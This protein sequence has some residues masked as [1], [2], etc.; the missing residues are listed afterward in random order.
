VLCFDLWSGWQGWRPLQ[1][2]DPPVEKGSFLQVDDGV[3]WSDG[4]PGRPV[5]VEHASFRARTNG[6]PAKDIWTRTA[7]IGLGANS[8]L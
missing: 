6:W 4:T 3:M 1:A 8:G 2:K 5:R 7:Q